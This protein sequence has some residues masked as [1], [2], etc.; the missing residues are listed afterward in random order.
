V[1]NKFK[2]LF[3]F[4]VTNTGGRILIRTVYYGREF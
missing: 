4:M 1:L 3:D 2:R